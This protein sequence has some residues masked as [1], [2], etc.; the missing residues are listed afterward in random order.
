MEVPRKVLPRVCS[1]TA[2]F[3]LSHISYHSAG[4]SFQWSLGNRGVNLGLRIKCR[5]YLD[6]WCETE[7]RG[8]PPWREDTWHQMRRS[9]GVRWGTAIDGGRTGGR[10]TR[11][12]QPGG[13]MM[14]GASAPADCLLGS[15]SLSEGQVR[16]L[17]QRGLKERSSGTSYLEVPNRCVCGHLTS[18]M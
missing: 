16:A 13:L 8:P 9:D 10:G 18:M 4:A 17:Y 3:W 1:F 2:P 14:A 7:V 11:A 12:H 5:P 6:R 15:L